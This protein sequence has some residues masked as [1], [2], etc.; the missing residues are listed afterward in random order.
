MRLV[1]YALLL[2][3]AVVGGLMR[4]LQTEV[5]RTGVG[6]QSVD[7]CVVVSGA[8]EEDVLGSVHAAIR[9]IKNTPSVTRLY[10]QVPD[11]DASATHGHAPTNSAAISSNK[12]V[13]RHISQLGL[14]LTI[15]PLAAD[16]AGWGDSINKHHT[17]WIRAGV[18]PPDDTVDRLYDLRR[19][20]AMHARPA[21]ARTT[22]EH[23]V[24][25]RA[26]IIG[27]LSHH[28]DEAV[29]YVVPLCQRKVAVA[30]ETLPRVRPRSRQQ[31]ME[32]AVTAMH[33]RT[34]VAALAVALDCSTGAVLL[35]AAAAHGLPTATIFTFVYFVVTAC[36]VPGVGHTSRLFYVVAPAWNVC[37]EFI[38][39]GA[40]AARTFRRYIGVR[41]MK[42]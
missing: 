41:K 37:T 38:V 26:R 12:L 6:F 17:L 18:L 20:V 16:A 35:W 8:D 9:I 7:S 11:A 14:S 30:A 24:T 10:V 25:N 19:T 13:V 34:W 33:A 23:V 27:M 4:A 21:P 1:W 5:P 29:R 3:R 31:V 32:M 22:F 2:L 15:H 42:H 40:Y 39:C 28:T 36:A